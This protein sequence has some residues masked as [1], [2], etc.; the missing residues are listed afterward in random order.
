MDLH[1]AA[2]VYDAVSL[3]GFGQASKLRLPQTVSN[4]IIIRVGEWSMMDLRNHA[5][6]K[7]LMWDQPWY[8]RNNKVNA[9]VNTKLQ[10][11][12][13]RARLPVPNSHSKTDDEHR[14]LLKRGESVLGTTLVTTILLAHFIATG[15]DLLQKQLCR[16]VE[17]PRR[18]N[19]IIVDMNRGRIRLSE[20]DGLPYSDICMGAVR[21]A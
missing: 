4:D 3:L 17:S 2:P 20:W 19:Y 21:I 1:T 10:A 15:E 6:T 11:G 12:I 5:T 9:W 16:T 14:T 8:I 18:G 7:A 13:Y